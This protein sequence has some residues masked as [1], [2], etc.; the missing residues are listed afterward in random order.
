MIAAG[1]RSV[2]QLASAFAIGVFSMSA[3]AEG[4]ENH[5]GSLSAD[6]V[7]KADV[8]H[9]VTSTVTVPSGITLTIEPGAIIKFNQSQSLNI[10]GVLDATGTEENK[11]IFTSY[12]D[13]IGGD[14]NG[15][16][17]SVGQPGDWYRI[18]FANSVVDAFT[19]LEHTRVRYAGYYSSNN[20]Y[21]YAAVYLDRANITIR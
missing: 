4:V 2:K 5:S 1:I 17:V 12:R 6:T 21:S 14:T 10:S 11:I 3:M 16:G 9:R 13:D 15:D 8:I 18:F 20:S 7:W 19:K